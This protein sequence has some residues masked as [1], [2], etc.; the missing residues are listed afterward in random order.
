MMSSFEPTKFYSNSKM[1]RLREWLVSLY[2]TSHTE[3]GQ[4]ES[5]PETKFHLKIPA[6]ME[7]S[8]KVRYVP[9]SINE[10]TTSPRRPSDP[11][12]ILRFKVI[13]ACS[14]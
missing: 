9:F 12:S 11:I 2:D 13:I 8:M 6:M 10:V 5:C 4:E 1:G 7:F 14:N 3:V